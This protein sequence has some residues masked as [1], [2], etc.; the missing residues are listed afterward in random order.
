MRKQIGS[1]GRGE[2]LRAVADRY[3]QASRGERKTV[4]DECV[5]ITGYHRKHAIRVLS[6]A[7]SRLTR[8]RRTRLRL[9]DEAVRESV[10]VLWEASD[11]LCGKRL[12]PLIP[13]LLEAL[14]R[15]GHLLL[16]EAVRARVLAISAATIDRL[17]APTRLAVRGRQ[18]A[19]AKPAIGSK[20]PIRTFRTGTSHCL[21]SWKSISSRTRAKAWLAASL[22]LWCS[23]ISPVSG[24]SAWPFP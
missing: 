8:V 24:P 7:D 12:K 19:S 22:T 16:D 15:H 2:L 14:Q 9:Y 3:R 23:R 1:A 21:A 18:R 6:A 4:L 10:V 20:V 17:L 5:A 11:R 13:V